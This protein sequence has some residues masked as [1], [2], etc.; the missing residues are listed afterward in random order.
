VVIFRSHK[1][2]REKTFWETLH[3]TADEDSVV[4]KYKGVLNYLR[5]PKLKLSGGK[6][7][8]LSRKK[9]LLEFPIYKIS[10]V[11]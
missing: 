10:G 9:K 6:S 5:I 2:V 3:Q 1:G 11:T 4:T 7:V 8:R